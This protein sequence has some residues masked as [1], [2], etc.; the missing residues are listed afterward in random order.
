MFGERNVEPEISV[1]RQYRF[2]CSCGATTETGERTVTCSGCG[3]VLAVRRIRRHR[4]HRRNSV[5]YYGST[6][7]VSHCST[8]SVR[9][10][11][12]HSQQPESAA[13]EAHKAGRVDQNVA[14][15]PATVLPR[16]TI[17]SRLHAW[18]RSALA[19][20]GDF[21][22]SLRVRK[23][24]Q[25]TTTV[26]KSEAQG[27]GLPAINGAPKGPLIEGAHVKVGPTRPNGTP[28]PHAGKTGRITKLVS[29]F[30]EEWYLPEPWPE[31]SALIE[32]DSGWPRRCIWVSLKCLEPLREE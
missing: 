10:V 29:A 7:S 11:E 25:H 30:S 23:H 20:S 6:R 8:V 27:H 13:G 1:E 22:K 3:A 12:R 16:T 21:L 9:R 32:L 14:P 5:A 18:V 4:Q 26:V 17:S 2:H 24:V 19:S 15:V 31:P 28:H